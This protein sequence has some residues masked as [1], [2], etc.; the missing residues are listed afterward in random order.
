M[1]IKVAGSQSKGRYH[2]YNKTLLG[3]HQVYWCSIVLGKLL[4][5]MFIRTFDLHEMQIC[6]TQS[7][8]AERAYRARLENAIVRVGFEQ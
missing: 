8:N 4:R 5:L 1:D 2:Q 6:R 3:K 7:P